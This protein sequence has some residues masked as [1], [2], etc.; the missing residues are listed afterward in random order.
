MT[1]GYTFY[2]K[3]VNCFTFSSN[4]ARP[5]EQVGKIKTLKSC[6]LNKNY[7]LLTSRVIQVH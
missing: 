5:N 2:F 4:Y 7:R 1:T 3:K 6:K